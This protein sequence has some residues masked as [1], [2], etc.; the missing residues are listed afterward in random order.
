MPHGA[1]CGKRPEVDGY[2]VPAGVVE[3]M[4]RVKTYELLAVKAAV[5]AGPACGSERRAHA[6][7]LLDGH[8]ESIPA[9]LDDLL[10]AHREYLPRFFA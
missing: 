1:L 5:E 4:T 9:L 10:N 2:P 6:H 7:P 8:H 3:L